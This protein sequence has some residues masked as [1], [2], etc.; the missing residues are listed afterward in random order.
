MQKA[1]VKL[2]GYLVG[3]YLILKLI[4][5]LEQA[6]STLEHV[7]WRWVVLALALETVSEMGFT[8]SWTAIVDPEGVLSGDGR[9]KRMDTHVAWA[10][11]GGG[12]LVPGGSLGGVGVGAWML[13][14]FGMPNKLVAERQFNLSFLNTGVDALALIVFGLALAIGVF[15]GARNLNL[16]LLP[17]C[18]AAIGVTAATLIARRESVARRRRRDIKHPKV[19]A[20]ITTLADAVDDTQ[21][22]L[23][24]RG[25]G[26]KAVLGALAYLGFDVLVLWSAFLAIGTHPTPSFAVVLM[27]YI[28]GALGGS[29]PLPAGLG[30]I[31]GM[32]GMLILYGVPHEAAVAA[33]VMYQ[34]VGM[35]VPLVGGGVAY[36]FVRRT[37]A[38]TASPDRADPSGSEEP[39]AGPVARASGGGN[40]FPEA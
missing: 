34:A 32:V 7:T 18:V 35:L 22:L 21:R 17:A 39:S 2:V 12:T 13:H 28:I 3:A 33:V 16:T 10:Q 36:M 4:P 19:A 9:D 40:P 1:A 31:G 5:G 8:L 14:R 24:H 27:A 20:A 11:L 37:L 38:D 26:S 23:F 15:S 30:S 25:A 6:L 29:L